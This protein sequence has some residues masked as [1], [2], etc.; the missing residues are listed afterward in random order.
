M[1]EIFFLIIVSA[2]FIQATLLSIGSKKSFPKIIGDELPKAT[3]IVAARNE[4]K[5]ILN[6]LISLNSLEY[7]DNK[8]EI[9]IV[10]DDST[11]S[12]EKYY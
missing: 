6:C 9:I 2:Y 8:L 5:N 1:F 11:D 10:D 4:E 3:V 12:T 7:P